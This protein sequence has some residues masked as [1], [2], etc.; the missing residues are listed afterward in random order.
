MLIA[1]WELLSNHLVIPHAIEVNLSF[2][3]LAICDK[4]RQQVKDSQEHLHLDDT[5][6]PAE[7]WWHW[8]KSPCPVTNCCRENFIKLLALDIAVN[9]LGFTLWVNPVGYPVMPVHKAGDQKHCSSACG[10]LSIQW[11]LQSSVPHDSSWNE[12][13]PDKSSLLSLT[14]DTQCLKIPKFWMSKPHFLLYLKT[15]LLISLF[16]TWFPRHFRQM[17]HLVKNQLRCRSW[18]HCLL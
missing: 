12:T 6:T 2:A 4:K 8:R 16:C 14:K 18:H 11:G 17:S 13:L 10:R 5:I 1:L 7:V 9:F 15:M 3:F